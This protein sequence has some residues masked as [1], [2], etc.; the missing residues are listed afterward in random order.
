MV[1]IRILFFDAFAAQLEQQLLSG[2]VIRRRFECGKG[3]LSGLV[4]QALGF[5]RLCEIVV[6]ARDVNRVERDKG[7][8][9]PRRESR[10]SATGC[11]ASRE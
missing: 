7:S 6:A 2:P 4:S 9:F 5:I 3:F 10:D 11:A 1:D 8:E